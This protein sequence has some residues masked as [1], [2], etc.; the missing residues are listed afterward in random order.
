AV[1]P[2]PRRRVAGVVGTTPA[3]VGRCTRA[4]T[5]ATSAT[6]RATSHPGGLHRGLSSFATAYSGRSASPA[7][8]RERSAVTRPAATTIPRGANPRPRRHPHHLEVL[9]HRH[10]GRRL[11]RPTGT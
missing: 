8:A 4:P 2:P 5:G 9:D 3:R 11:P 1:Q 10:R 7:P 6:H